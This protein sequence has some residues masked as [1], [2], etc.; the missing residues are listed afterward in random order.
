M[1]SSGQKWHKFIGRVQRRENLQHALHSKQHKIPFRY[2]SKEEF[3]TVS[4]DFLGSKS[5]YLSEMSEP[6]NGVLFAQ[7]VFHFFCL[8]CVPL[9]SVEE[10]TGWRG[11]LMHL[12][13]LHPSEFQHS[14][15]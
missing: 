15:P 2:F 12:I 11:K 7:S 14:P 6:E 4:L 1:I 9:E 8:V 3:S 13:F 5:P 10:E